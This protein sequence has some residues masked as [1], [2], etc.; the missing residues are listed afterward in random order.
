MFESLYNVFR[1][2]T[3]I[4]DEEL[5][6]EL[7]NTFEVRVNVPDVD[8]RIRICLTPYSVLFKYF[9][10]GDDEKGERGRTIDSISFA[11]RKE[12]GRDLL[13]FGK[14]CPSN[15]FSCDNK[16]DSDGGEFCKVI[17]E[18]F[19]NFPII[20][21]QA[22]QDDWS[23]FFLLAFLLSFLFEFEI[24]ESVFGSSPL[25]DEVRNKLRTSKVYQLLC[26]KVKYDMLLYK[27]R[28]G[29]MHALDK[30]EYDYIVRCYADLLMDDEYNKIVPPEYFDGKGWLYDP[31][32]ELEGIVEDNRKLIR[33]L[34]KSGGRS[35]DGAFNTDFKDKIRNYFYTKHSVWRAQLSKKEKIFYGIAQGIMIVFTLLSGVAMLF[36]KEPRCEWFTNWYFSSFWLIASSAVLGVLLSLIIGAHISKSFNV[37]LPRIIVSVAIMWLMTFISEDLIKSQI[38]IDK[39]WVLLGLACVL[40]SIVVVLL[41]GEIKQH[42]PYTSLKYGKRWLG[43]CFC[44]LNYFIFVVGIFGMMMQLLFYKDLLRGSQALPEIVYE[45][46]YSQPLEEYKSALGNLQKNISDYRDFVKYYSVNV[47]DDRQ[48]FSI[49]DTVKNYHIEFEQ[50]KTTRSK[51]ELAPDTNAYYTI[52]REFNDNVDGIMALWDAIGASSPVVSVY[53]HVYD[54]VEIM[55]DTSLLKKN[56][57]IVDGWLRWLRAEQ[58]KVDDALQVDDYDTLLL[59]ATYPS[60]V[61]DNPQDYVDCLKNK[62]IQAHDVCRDVGKDNP[63]K[64]FPHLLLI[65]SLIVLILA[66]IGQLFLTKETVS[67]PL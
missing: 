56:D 44:I 45:N 26:A 10:E 62:A 23:K 13:D 18:I 25:Y 41:Y 30:E 35:E 22:A 60:N 36:F 11:T 33:H 14:K 54:I 28:N 2:R 40:F 39:I 8:Y 52:V 9:K 24:R 48:N 55:K 46:D 16:E 66:F 67:E 49:I 57:T 50:K 17:Q 20:K 61:I 63:K 32:T 7:K 43:K 42:S 15:L 12:T 3:R 6:E 37:F 27:W 1:Y 19:Y 65:H 21:Q 4:P 34:R 59:W 53:V 5:P 64:I 31:E 58:C 47:A 29:G 38:L 51:T